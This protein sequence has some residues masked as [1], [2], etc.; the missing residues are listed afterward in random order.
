MLLCY[1][2]YNFTLKFVFV[3]S[4]KSLE[5]ST[6]YDRHPD[7][8]N[9]TKAKANATLKQ[10]E[11]KRQDYAS[12]FVKERSVLPHKCIFQRCL[13]LSRGKRRVYI[14]YMCEIITANYMQLFFL[15]RTCHAALQR[16]MNVEKFYVSAQT[17]QC[18]HAL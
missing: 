8:S 3:Q 9:I 14:N 10:N 11:Q 5:R 18:G 16:Y 13:S 6:D 1:I 15:T 12:Y 4:H 7:T 2:V 17:D